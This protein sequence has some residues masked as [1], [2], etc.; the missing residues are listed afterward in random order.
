MYRKRH[1]RIAPTRIVEF[2]LLDSEF[3]RAIRY[4]LHA[5]ARVAARHLRHAGRHVPQS[6]RAAA[7]ASSAPSS[8]TR[9]ST[10]S[11]RRPARVPRRLQTKMN[12]VGNGISETFFAGTRRA[13]RPQEGEG[14]TAAAPIRRVNGHGC[15]SRM[16]I[17]V[18]LSHRTSYRYDR[19][20]RAVAARHPAAAGA[21]LPHADPE[22]L[23]EGRAASST[24]STGSRIR[25]ATTSRGSSFPSQTR[26]A[27]R[28]RS[29][30]SP[31]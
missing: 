31:R 8:P 12:Q 26:R 1:G 17:H 2:L 7:R 27:A 3:P 18:A 19:L 21:A 15:P 14:T 5:G 16:A 30:W 24:S 4:C 29:I 9:R 13:A 11:S 6:G 22:L 20:G 23:A 10:T 25:T 28:S